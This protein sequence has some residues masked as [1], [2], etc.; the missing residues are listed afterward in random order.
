MG[1]SGGMGLEVGGRTLQNAQ[2]TLEVKDPQ[3]SKGGTLDEMPD[4]RERELIEP[5]ASKKTGCQV[6]NEVAILQSHL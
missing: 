2:E 1:R 4:G 3:D 5:T 6:R